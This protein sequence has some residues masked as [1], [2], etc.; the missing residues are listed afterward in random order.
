MRSKTGTTLGVVLAALGV[1]LLAGAAVLYWWIVPGQKQIPADTNTT[2]QYTGV[3]RLLLDPKALGAGDLSAAVIRDAPVT[4]SRT[5]TVLATSGSAAEVSDSRTLIAGGQS[6]GHT[7]QTYAV[8]RTSLERAS[9]HPSDWNVVNQQGLTVSW[10][11]GAKQQDYQ[12]WV[13]ET[14][15]ATTL[16]YVRAEQRGGISTYVYEADSP[17][18]PIKDPQ[19]LAGLPTTLPVTALSGL[20]S[21]LPVP[22]PLKAQ[23]AQALPSLSGSVPLTYTYESK[24][25]YW[26]EPTTGIVVD[27]ELEQVRKAGLAA[28]GAAGAAIPVYDVITANTAQSVADAASDASTDKDKIIRYGQTLPLLLLSLGVVALAGGV[29]LILASRRSG[30][31]EHAATSTTG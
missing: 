25:V 20:A 22:D 31:G 12:G 24:S 21:A 6:V 18:S 8:D 3:A 9:N 28:S 23:L 26:V 11:I 1:V 5:V 17:A 15:T 29:I 16:R 14:Q 2:R 4:A 19:V 10:P 13:N 27:S 7:A 30:R